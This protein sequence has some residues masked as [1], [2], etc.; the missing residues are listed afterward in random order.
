MAQQGH[1]VAQFSVAEF[2]GAVRAGHGGESA[3]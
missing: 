3:S 2:C 1:V